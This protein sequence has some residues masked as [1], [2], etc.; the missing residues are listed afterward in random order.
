MTTTDLPSSAVDSSSAVDTSAVVTRAFD[1]VIAAIDSGRLQPGD[2]LSDAKFAELLGVSRTPVREAFQR[3][4]EIGLIEA[5][6]NRFT[7]VSIISPQE[8]G[9]AL[10][11]W[12]ALF[13]A[14]LDEVV[15]TAPDE[16]VATM[17]LHHGAFVQ[18]SREG[19]VQRI[20][21]TNV[22][23]FGAAAKFSQNPTLQYALMASMQ[24]VRLGGLRLSAPIDFALIVRAQAILLAGVGERDLERALESIGVLRGL[25]IPGSRTCANQ[26]L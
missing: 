9:D 18:A 8:T 23:F 21:S 5:S 11:V 14:V 4:R 6:A 16:L 25:S 19:D 26:P 7:R 2:R 17:T 24:L 15:P 1:E 20:A 10:V 13:G 12:L 3:L 22:A